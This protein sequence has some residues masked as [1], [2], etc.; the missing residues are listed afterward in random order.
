MTEKRYLQMEAV[1]CRDNDNGE[2]IVSGYAIK[3]GKPSLD[4][5]GFIE[6]VER[7]ALNDSLE[8]NDILALYDHKTGNILGRTSSGTLKLENRDEGLYFRLSLPNTSLGRDIYES[9]Q[10]GDLKGMSFG[11][12]VPKG[13]TRWEGQKRYLKNID[14][15]EISIVSMPAYPDTEVLARTYE[16]ENAEEIEKQNAEKRDAIID[17]LN[18]I[19]K[20]VHRI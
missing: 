15:H 12:R 6:Y 4:L 14:M 7:G 13:G 1:E 19:I 5:G 16:V 9:V 8:K 10:R 20:E 18:N 17:E 11:F 2:R 3:Y